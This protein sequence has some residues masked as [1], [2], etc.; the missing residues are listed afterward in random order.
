[1]IYLLRHGLD[2]ESYVG[3]YSDVKLTSEGIKQ[4]KE[5]TH[6]LKC[7]GIKKIYTSDVQRAID[8]SNYV[9]DILNVQIQIDQNLRELDKGVL[10]GKLKSLLTE[11]ELINLNT[12]D[13]TEKIGNGESMLDLYKRV[14]KLLIDGYFEDKD[15]TLIVT[16]RGFI[17]MLY[18]LL[19]DVELSIN[20][21]LF[22]VTHGSVHELDI[23]NKKIKKLF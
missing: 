13:I 17:N 20:K 6:K 3:G 1:M 7:L 15:S 8:T 14:R 22:D 9:N 21:N 4:I 12:K 16:H 10:N 5:T 19:R 2:D 11:E 23:K 18:F